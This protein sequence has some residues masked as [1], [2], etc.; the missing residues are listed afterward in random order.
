MLAHS[1][2]GSLSREDL[3]K[4]RESQARDVSVSAQTTSCKQCLLAVQRESRVDV[5]LQRQ[6]VPLRAGQELVLM[7]RI[8]F[9]EV[10]AWLK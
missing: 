4:M 9:H 1:S 5:V 2:H 10:L 7:G 8:L 6:K 3:L